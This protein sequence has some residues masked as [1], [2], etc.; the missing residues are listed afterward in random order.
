MF[1]F[2]KPFLRLSHR[3]DRCAVWRACG[4][5]MCALL[6]LPIL[7]ALIA[8]AYVAAVFVGSDASIWGEIWV[9]VGITYGIV[10]LFIISPLKI[11]IVWWVT[12]K[13]CPPKEEDFIE[14]FE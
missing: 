9:T 1:S 13:C 6:M 3:V 14:M 7:A 12:M 4:Y 5:I 8:A 2:M 11:T 10:H